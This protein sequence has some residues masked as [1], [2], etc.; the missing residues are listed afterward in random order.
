MVYNPTLFPSTQGAVTGYPGPANSTLAL[1]ACP[2]PDLYNK[3]GKKRRRHTRNKYTR[4]IRKTR[5]RI[6]RNL[7]R[8]RR[9][10][11]RRKRRS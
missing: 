3:G 9:S 8:M 5:R 1:K 6:R 11:T 7:R 10:L 4:R 2:G